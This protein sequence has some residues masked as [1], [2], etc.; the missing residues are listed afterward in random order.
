MTVTLYEL[1]QRM[2]DLKTCETGESD[3]AIY[4]MIKSCNY[5]TE[6][7]NKVEISEKI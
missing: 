5:L 6:L 3:S 4:L 7:T 1:M 2:E